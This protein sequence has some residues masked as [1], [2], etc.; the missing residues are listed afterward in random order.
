MY[1]QV[2]DLAGNGPATA[3]L[4][5]EHNFLPNSPPPMG[6]NAT[7]GRLT[8]L[9]HCCTS[10]H[11]QPQTTVSW[12]L[13]ASAIL[14]HN[15][16]TYLCQEQRIVKMSSVGLAGGAHMLWGS[17]GWRGLLSLESAASAST[18]VAGLVIKLSDLYS[19]SLQQKLRRMKAGCAPI[20]SVSVCIAHDVL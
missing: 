18:W 4:E 5:H 3:C 13:V 6:A 11:H 10:L 20:Q 15:T 14:L 2:S 8:G 7:N 19:V 9:T 1:A 17:A 16:S 12:T